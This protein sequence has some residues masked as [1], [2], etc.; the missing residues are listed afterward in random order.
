M[1]IFQ[2]EKI[3]LRER[4]LKRIWFSDGVCFKKRRQ[5]GAHPQVHHRHTVARARSRSVSLGAGK[6]HSPNRAGHARSKSAST[7][8]KMEEREGRKVEK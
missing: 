4:R 5:P 7:T 3:H 1:V 2:E 8:T 6:T